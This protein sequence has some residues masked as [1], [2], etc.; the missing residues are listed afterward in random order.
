MKCPKCDYLGF[1]TGDR[2]KNCGYNFSL[3]PPHAPPSSDPTTLPEPDVFLQDLDRPEGI[4]SGTEVWLDRVDET[5]PPIDIGAIQP[6]SDVAVLPDLSM[7]SPT[8]GAPAMV[9]PGTSRREIGSAGPTRA[10]RLTAHQTPVVALPL[11]GQGSEGDQEPLIKVPRAP[12]PPLSVRRTPD[13]PRL[14]AV[15]KPQLPRSQPRHESEPEPS[16]PE[17]AITPADGEPPAME[18][19]AS[20][21]LALGAGT[22]EPGSAAR[23]LAAAAIDV[24]IL[25]MIDA[26]VVYFTLRMAALT[27]G[28]WALLPR[29]PLATFLVLIALAYLCAFTAIGGQTIGKMAVRIRVVTDGEPVP[30]AGQAVRRTLAAVLTAATCG[31]GYLPGLFGDRRALHDRLARTRVVSA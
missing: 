12:R 18:S 29:L 27:T 1:E 9:R 8:S 4:G 16:F 31:L 19:P 21:G 17:L 20:R 11:F 10:E 28:D 30:A 2:C 3:I 22:V 14:R 23:R 7:L 5:L 26:A 24:A 6:H 13:T 25:L 15:A